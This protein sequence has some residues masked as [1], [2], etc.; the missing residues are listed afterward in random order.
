[1]S[2]S[3]RRRVVESPDG[4]RWHDSY[5]SS[6]NDTGGVPEF[7]TPTTSMSD[8]RSTTATPRVPR[9]SYS[10]DSSDEGGAVST[11]PA[12]RH[13]NSRR[14]SPQFDLCRGDHD[15]MKPDSERRR[16]TAGERCYDGGRQR[17]D[18]HRS[19]KVSFYDATR[20]TSRV[21]VNIS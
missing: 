16:T 5:V 1:M 20:V 3:R 10:E 18:H 19:R 13:R 6:V 15:D 4:V 8:L 21:S 9:W 12:S 14:D 7:H 11:K 17:R 2:P